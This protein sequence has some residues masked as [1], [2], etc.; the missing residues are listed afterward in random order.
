[1]TARFAKGLCLLALVFTAGCGPAPSVSGAPA[2]PAYVQHLSPDQVDTWRGVHYDGL[3][4][5][6]R[7]PVE[8]EDDL[9]HLD[10]A[11]QVPVE[12]LESRMPELERY[13]ARSVLIYDRTGPRAT[14][15]GQILVMHDFKDVS[16][17]DGGLK[18]YREWQATR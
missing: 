16:M 17:L 1:M 12:D 10:N 11:V 18:A 2:T 15:A 3:I 8:W 7:S 6:V 14:R 9:L 13:R 4:L 5:D